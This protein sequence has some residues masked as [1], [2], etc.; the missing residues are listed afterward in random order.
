M[1]GLAHR[2]VAPE[3]KGNVADAPADFGPRQVG[4]DPFRRPDEIHR[5]IRVFLHA[6][7]DGQHVRIENNV[8][9]REA[10]FLHQQVVGAPAD[11]GFALEGVRL[12]AFIERH[13]HHRRA[14][15]QHQPGVV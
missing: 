8:L 1:H 13:H 15:A 5:V 9:W 14:V 6:R 7:A 10:D 3:R 11:F 12:P 4:L 2:I